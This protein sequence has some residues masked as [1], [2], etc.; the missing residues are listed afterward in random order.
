MNRFLLNR[1]MMLV[2]LAA[3]SVMPRMAFAQGA[4]DKFLIVLSLR[5][6]MDGLH[7]VIPVGD[8]HYQGLRGSIAIS[9]DAAKPLDGF[10]ALH[11]AFDFLHKAYQTKEVLLFHA[12]ASPYR[13]RSHFDGQAVLDN[14]GNGNPDLIRDGWLNRAINLIPGGSG[15]AVGQ[16]V[17]LILRGEGEVT[18]WGPSLLPDTDP[19]TIERLSRLY[20]GDPVFEMSLQRAMETDALTKQAM[21]EDAGNNRDTDAVANNVASL[22][23]ADGGP[24]IAVVELDRWDTHANQGGIKGK[25]ATQF[26]RLDGL[27]RILAQ[28]F[29]AQWSNTAIVVITEF[30]RTAAVNGNA[31]T[32][33]GTGSVAM[34]LGGAVNGGKVMTDWPGLAK[35]NLFEGRDLNPTSDLRSMLKGVLGDHLGLGN[36]ALSQDVFP[37]SSAIKPMRDLIG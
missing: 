5:G 3:S 33:H 35:N 20:A 22:M 19:A 16:T 8:P 13:S 6:A 9:A 18:S 28:K 31:G 27:L 37:D 10:F 23:L 11:P 17:P 12:I 24:R 36:A 21:G 30:G 2:G 34:A 26:G 4:K 7:S 25:L 1:R 14:G 15:L 32:D 29:A